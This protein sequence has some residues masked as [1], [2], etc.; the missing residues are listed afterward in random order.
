MVMTRPPQKA[1][2]ALL[3]DAS[4]R[5]RTTARRVCMFNIL[6]HERFLKREHLII[7]VEGM[8]GKGCFGISAVEDTFYRDMKVAKDAFKAAGYDLGYSRS[9]TRPGYYLVGQAALGAELDLALQGSIDEVSQAQI[10]IYRR[11][12]PARCFQQGCSISDTA[13][14]VVVY[15]IRQRNPALSVSEAQRLALAHGGT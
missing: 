13:R 6:L 14:E 8:L 9:A 2:E 12:S 7:R 4:R 1:V 11:M 5:D 15:R 10:S 3:Q